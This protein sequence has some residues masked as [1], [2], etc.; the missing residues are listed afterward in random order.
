MI[1]LQDVTKQFPSG[2]IAL[3]QLSLQVGKKEL[4]TVVGP[5]GSGKTTLLRLIAGLEQPTSGRILF[6]GEDVASR[7]PHARRIGM[8]F[9]RQN[10]LEHLSVLDNLTFSMRMR[11]QSRADQ[12]AKVDRVIELLDL[13]E[14]LSRWPQELSGGEQ[15]RIAIGRALVDD[16]TTLL[17]D[18]PLAQLDAVRQVEL[19]QLI[20]SLPA[21]TDTTV[22]YVTHDQSEALAL[23]DRIAVLSAGELAQIGP[24]Q[25]VY[26]APATRFV[27]RFIGSPR[28]NLLVGKQ[29]GYDLEISG[30]TIR[31]PD[32]YGSD[33]AHVEVGIR[34][35]DV[36]I[37]EAANS[38]PGE[39]Q[40]VEFCGH[41]SIAYVRVTGQPE[42]IACRVT[43]STRL[44]S[45]ERIHLSI[46]SNRL[47]LF[48]P[49]GSVARS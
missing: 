12:Q 44:N 5:S 47:H 26:Q 11:R 43:G 46:N 40:H 7:E 41:E 36:T 27:A 3:R 45:G 13:T 24:P 34:P 4:L 16:V 35:E 31:L 25:E 14:L 32:A 42:L 30:V 15:Q 10:L 9:Q 49:D 38:L 20:R 23:G 21:T 19:R 1:E 2:N 33:R 37:G 6:A 28:M 39:V 18:E 22:I 8:V 29:A 17:L 48:L